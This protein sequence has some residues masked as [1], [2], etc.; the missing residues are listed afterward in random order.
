MDYMRL[1]LGQDKVRNP[2]LCVSSVG[3][4]GGVPSA[5]AIAYSQKMLYLDT[6]IGSGARL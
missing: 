1:V 4:G 3:G 6:E 2:E 5:G